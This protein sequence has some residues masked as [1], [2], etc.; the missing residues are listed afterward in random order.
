MEQERT[1]QINPQRRFFRPGIINT[2]YNADAR[3][4]LQTRG[5]FDAFKPVYDNTN[6]SAF[7]PCN[8]TNRLQLNHD[9]HMLKH[10]DL[11]LISI[12]T[13]SINSQR[14]M[15]R[16]EEVAR[17]HEADIICVQ[18]TSMNPNVPNNWQ[19]NGYTIVSQED[20]KW[21]SGDNPGWKGGSCIFVK[22]NYVHLCKTIV[23]D[24]G[25]EKCQISA[26]KFD[27]MNIINT[28]RSPN[29]SNDEA[30]KLA[31]I[32]EQKFPKNDTF[33]VGDWN[34]N[35]TD[36]LNK[37]AHS[38]DQKAIIKAFRESNFTQHV[39]TPT[40]GNNILDLCLSK[41]KHK[42]R[43]VFVDYEQFRLNKKNKKVPLFDHFPV[44]VK[45]ATRPNYKAYT[46]KKDLKNVD[47]YKYQE[48]VLNKLNGLKYEHSIK[49]FKVVIRGNPN[50]C[51]CGTYD[52]DKIGLCSCGQKCDPKNEIEKR[53][54][55]ISKIIHESFMEACPTKKVWLYTPSNN[56]ISKEVID[57]K[58][59]I[60]NHKNKKRKERVQELQIELQE[61]INQD[62]EKEAEDLI[63]FWQENPNNCYITL[64]RAKKGKAKSNGLYKDIANGNKDITYDE[65][66]QANI[67]N[68]HGA[69]VLIKSDEHQF[70][71]DEHVNPS[72]S[73]PYPSRLREP[74]IT[75]EIIS[76]IID[77]KLKKKYSSGIDGVSVYMLKALENIII[78]P[79]CHLYRLSY[80]FKYLPIAW[81]T[82][83]QTYIP[84]KASDLCNPNNLRGLNM[85]SCT[86][87]PFEMLLTE[88]TYM[89]MED[90]EMIDMEQFGFRKLLG[91]ELQLVQFWDQAT[92]VL[93]KPNVERIVVFYWD[94]EKAF[95]KIHWMTLN[96]ELFNH[97][98]SN[99]L[100]NFYQNWLQGS[101]QYVQVGQAKSDEIDVSSS[102]K[103]G[104]IFAGKLG[105]TIVI[106]SLFDRLKKK[107]NQLG[108]GEYFVIKS[109]ADDTKF[110]LPIRKEFPI[111]LEESIHQE[112][113]NEFNQW[114]IEQQLKINANKSLEL[115]IGGKIPS[116]YK[117]FFNGMEIVTK[118][119]GNRL[120]YYNQ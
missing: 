27:N 15:A 41:D 4:P 50:W 30:F 111:E 75:E 45:F 70:E 46:T 112:M 28:Y 18:E 35:E 14:G 29:M 25:L 96:Q 97:R 49:H 95:D 118:K 34:L 66:E 92:H 101:K 114:T 72:D 98:I 99:G 107:A 89:Q 56:R 77:E 42:I 86:Y 105:F 6:N 33:V 104:S 85:C 21:G 80:S 43:E 103:Q 32:I 110:I 67:L 78:K 1:I 69:R 79:L 83:K 26:T 117:V 55:D 73:A 84:K 58:R 37:T 19:M 61:K 113:I 81:R 44:V 108:I 116:T 68:K 3:Y 64:E 109:Y 20:K 71:W 36:F 5:I 88:N 119:I 2:I 16:L 87:F 13:T 74:E 54:Q 82:C 63:K 51:I 48:L 8:I 40:C 11:T 31:E 59:R 23:I 62:L 65:T 100:G 90:S 60:N 12:N 47:L 9:E 17:F 102:I 24:H 53:Q 115:V 106:N 39:I 76:Y 120:R 57:L 93:Q 94:F 22:N 91:T 38:K 52:C 7:Y 10:K